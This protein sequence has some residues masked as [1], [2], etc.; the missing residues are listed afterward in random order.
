M[1]I[2]LSI[3]NYT[4]KC[5]DKKYTHIYALYYVLA[6]LPSHFLDCGEA[7]FSFNFNFHNELTCTLMRKL[8]NLAAAI[9]YSKT[10]FI[11]N[12]MPWLFTV[13]LCVHI[14]FH[15]KDQ[16]LMRYK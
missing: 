7:K 1:W 5:F 9:F 11:H 3:S 16:M 10:D 12:K 15:A 4:H 14:T 6:Y 2:E 13:P 8:N